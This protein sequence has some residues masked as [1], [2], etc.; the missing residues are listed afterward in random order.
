MK[1]TNGYTGHRWTE[2]ETM[3]LVAMW[4]NG[5]AVEAIAA[6]FNVTARGINTHITRLRANGIPI[7]RRAAGHQA[8]RSN[9]P[10]TQEEVEFLIRRRTERATAEQIANELNRSF[11]G[12][13]GMIQRL[14]KESVDLPMYGMGVRRLWDPQKLRDAIAMR[15]LVPEEKRGRKSVMRLVRVDNAATAILAEG[16]QIN[17]KQQLAEFVSAAGID[18]AMKRLAS[19]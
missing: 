4:A 18:G 7:P 5:D 2:Q 15:G 1:K 11:L 9:Q 6:R 3:E 12:V 8:G 17:K 13:Q 16:R 10:W 19:K 14:R